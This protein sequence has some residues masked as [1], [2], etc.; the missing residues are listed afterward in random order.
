MMKNK[1]TKAE[2]MMNEVVEVATRLTIAT[3]YFKFLN[4]I[5]PSD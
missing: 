2:E 3:L 4:D 5:L 1:I